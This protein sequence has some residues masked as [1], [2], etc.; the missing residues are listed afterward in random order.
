MAKRTV[1]LALI[2]ALLAAGG[3]RAQ[4]V[5]Y[6]NLGTFAGNASA[7]G[8]AISQSGNTIT[9]MEADDI[10]P[11]AGF[12]GSSV[13]SFSFT[14]ANTNATAVTARA[15][16]RFWNNS[17][18][19]GGPGT[20]LYTFDTPAQTYAA[21]SV[22]PQPVVGVPAGSFVLPSGTF[23]AGLSFDDNNG[24]TGATVAQL[25]NLGQGIFNPPTVGSSLDRLFDTSSAGTFN[26]NNP[27]GSI[28]AAPFG[29]NPA[30]NLGWQFT[31]QAV[32]E[33][34]TLALCGFAAASFAG[35][36]WR[37]RRASQVVQNT[38]DTAAAV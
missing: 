37:R 25:N 14:V 26:F 27:S 8:G 31:V 35:S 23:W 19:G 38:V 20:L 29:G 4:V 9:I 18:P 11:V 32:P 24:T 10:T 13:T 30:A 28:L 21:N 2:A 16:A 34:T 22:S 12:A 1:G 17:G 6:S 5:V 15:H 7:N 33:P 3:A 36:A